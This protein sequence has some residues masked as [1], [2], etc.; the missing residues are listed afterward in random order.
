M[1]PCCCT[2]PSGGMSVAPVTTAPAGAGDTTMCGGR[3]SDRRR[4][5]AAAIAEPRT[6]RP[7]TTTSTQPRAIGTPQRHAASAGGAVT[8]VSRHG[9]RHRVRLPHRLATVSK[10]CIPPA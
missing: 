3:M 1:P 10:V 5:A 6:K 2:D 8:A 9:S 7:G 4:R